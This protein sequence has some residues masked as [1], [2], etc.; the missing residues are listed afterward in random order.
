MTSFDHLKVVE[1]RERI[2]LLKELGHIARRLLMNDFGQIE[3]Y[4]LKGEVDVVTRVDEAVEAAT[5]SRIRTL[6]RNDTVI[7]EE[8]SEFKGDSGYSWVIDPLDG[9]T[10]YAH[11][12]PFFA[13]SCGLRRGDEAMAGVVEVPFTGETFFAQK[14][15]G[16]WLNGKP[17]RVSAVDRLKRALLV[18]G[19]PYFRVE[20]V[21]NLLPPMRRAVLKG[22]GLRRGGAA[23]V[24]MCYLACGRLDGY[25]EIGLKPWDMAAGELII[26]EAGGRLSDY[27]SGPFSIFGKELVASNGRIHNEL[28]EEVLQG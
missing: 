5:V 19:L 26:R 21:D 18:T 6:F 25:F 20:V 15:Q 2:G 22:Q 12:Y 9:T 14:G 17:I 1:E 24:D 13:F 7:A 16:S 23:A 28:V 27:S 11:G 3:E 4:R 10:N 8:G